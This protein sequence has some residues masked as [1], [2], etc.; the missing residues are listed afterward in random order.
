MST[1]SPP[2]R[3][4]WTG[5]ELRRLRRAH[6][7]CCASAVRQ[8]L[9]RR[10]WPLIC[11]GVYVTAADLARSPLTVTP[12]ASHVAGRF[13]VGQGF[14]VNP[15]TWHTLAEHGIA[16]RGAAP[17]ALRIHTD[18][19]QLRA[20]TRAN[21]DG[22]WR[23]WAEATRGHGWM[24]VKAMWRRFAAWGVL[25]APRLHYTIQ[26]GDIASKEAAARH[27]LEVFD[28]RWHALIEDAVGFL[29]GEPA[30]DRYRDPVRRRRDSA[31]FVAY[32]VQ[33]GA[34]AA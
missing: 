32:V 28:P 22:Y 10:G 14:D 23:E 9:T 34:G 33:A 6:V 3:V 27:A 31:D 30:D 26:T 18:A 11:N 8:A 15:V 4:L 16:L 5:H 12:V 1:S 7:S 25:G 17:H 2:S 19:G 29:R 24:A 13:L 20:W 21:L